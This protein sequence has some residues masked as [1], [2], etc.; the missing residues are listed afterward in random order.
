MP[1]TIR[2]RFSFQILCRLCSVAEPSRQGSSIPRNYLKS[3]LFTPALDGC[4]VRLVW[5]TVLKFLRSLC[6]WLVG[7][8]RME[9]ASRRHFIL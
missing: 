2:A 8:Y 6:M 7:P 9:L 5:L 3:Q 1:G 4:I